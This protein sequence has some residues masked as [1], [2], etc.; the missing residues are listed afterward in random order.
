M[1]RWRGLL[2]RAA[3]VRSWPGNRDGDENRTFSVN[4][5]SGD[6]EDNKGGEKGEREHVTSWAVSF[7]G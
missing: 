3:E 7:M 2:N 4:D 6:D 1:G 5:A